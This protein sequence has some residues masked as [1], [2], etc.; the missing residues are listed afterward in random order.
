MTKKIIK[1]NFMKK[2]KDINKEF[3]IIAANMNILNN[4]FE[5]FIESYEEDKCFE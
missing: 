4:Y 5:T 2:L 1:K 3:A